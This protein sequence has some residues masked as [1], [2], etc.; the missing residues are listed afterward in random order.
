MRSCIGPIR[1]H[2]RAR[3]FL[4]EVM[5][6]VVA[7]GRASGVALPADFADE[8]LAFIDG[9]PPAMEASM[10]AD[11]QRGGRLE[12][13]WLSGTVADMGERAGVPTPMNR[14]VADVLAIHVDGPPRREPAR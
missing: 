9:L 6:E 13:P 5:R 10:Y 12:L 1:S 7:L 14:A 3:A 8:R 4:L 11:L 2:P